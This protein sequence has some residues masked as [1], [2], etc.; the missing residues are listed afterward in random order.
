MQ[1]DCVLWQFFFF[2]RRDGR[3]GRGEHTRAAREGVGEAF[4]FLSPAPTTIGLT[5]PRRSVSF[6]SAFLGLT[7]DTLRGTFPFVIRVVSGRVGHRECRLGSYHRGFAE[8]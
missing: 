4:S 8:G 7:G 1:P 2:G 5:V 3:L 6:L